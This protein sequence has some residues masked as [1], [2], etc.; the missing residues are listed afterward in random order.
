MG[1]DD[2]AYLVDKDSDCEERD[3][4]L[5]TIHVFRRFWWRE[6]AVLSEAQQR[7]QAKKPAALR[8]E[9]PKIW[10]LRTSDMHDTTP[11]HT[12]EFSI[13]W[14]TPRRFRSRATA[15]LVQQFEGALVYMES[16]NPPKKTTLYA[17]ICYMSNKKNPPQEPRIKK[18]FNIDEPEQWEAFLDELS[19]LRHPQWAAAMFD[20]EH[21]ESTLAPQQVAYDER[22]SFAAWQAERNLDRLGERP[23]AVIPASDDAEL[24]SQLARKL[25]ARYT[26][27][28][29]TGDNMIVVNP[30][31]PEETM[32][33]TARR[34]GLW[35]EAMVSSTLYLLSSDY[36]FSL[37]HDVSV[38]L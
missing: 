34:V 31:N 2:N 38:F 33:L 36:V 5:R 10:K 20:M 17:C 22:A 9:P 24:G 3:D 12:F 4:E 7:A 35:A 1:A 26:T 37:A 8:T 27:G 6:S 14:D 18:Q 21:P 19:V 11:E 25:K 13:R 28:Q 23:Q 30:D 29:G 15:I 16:L 32:R